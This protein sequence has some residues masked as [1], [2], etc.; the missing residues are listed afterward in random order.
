VA[1]PLRYNTSAMLCA[2]AG[3]PSTGCGE[4][5]SETSPRKSPTATAAPGHG[6]SQNDDGPAV[7]LYA[8]IA[9][10]ATLA[11]AAAWQSRRRRNATD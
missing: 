3:Y 2:I 11:A 8:G 5:V 9:L 10:V 6:T 7:G 1:D 4:Q